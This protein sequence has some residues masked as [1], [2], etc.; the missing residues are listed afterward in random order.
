MAAFSTIAA[1]GLGAA[2]V[3]SSISGS[4]RAANAVEDAAQTSD[5]TQRY[6]YDDIKERSAF[7]EDIGNRAIGQLAGL[8][9]LTSEQPTQGFSGNGVPLGATPTGGRGVDLTGRLTNGQQGGFDAQ[10]YLQANPDVA[11][12]FNG[13][14]FGLSP[15]AFALAHWNRHGQG[16]GRQGAFGVPQTPVQGQ[17]AQPQVTPPNMPETTPQGGAASKFADFYASPD[18]QLA[19]TEGQDAI[20]G[21]AAARGGLLSGNTAKA[22]TAFGQD[23]ATSTFG[24]YRGALQNLAGTGQQATQTINQAGQNYA[25][26]FSNNAFAVGNANAQSAM[27][28]GNTI[29]GAAGFGLGILGQQNNWWGAK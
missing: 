7:R 4:K 21:S 29:G 10:S 26:N 14:S 28:I 27:N 9:G 12:A 13:N 22:I 17:Q 25:N 8:Y 5:A 1:V 23:L 3:A 2:G 6:I 11:A 20:E 16:E 15:E 19:F 18:Y 24:N